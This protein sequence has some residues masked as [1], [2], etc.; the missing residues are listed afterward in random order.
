[1]SDLYQAYLNVCADRDRLLRGEFTKEELMDI[2]HNLHGTCSAQEFADGCA[3]EQRKLYGCAPDRDCLEAVRD[4][5]D[6]RTDRMLAEIETAKDKAIRYRNFWYETQKEL[7]LVTRQL[8]AV[9]NECTRLLE[10]NRK[11]CHTK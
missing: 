11:L 6:T 5:L 4:K 7:E 3:A 2:C 10:L 8:T 9:Q 1:M